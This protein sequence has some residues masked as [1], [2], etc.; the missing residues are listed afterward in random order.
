MV[1][2]VQVQRNSGEYAATARRAELMMAVRRRVES[3][4]IG[5]KNVRNHLFAVRIDKVTSDEIRQD[6]VL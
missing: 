3:N 1:T 5:C 4:D 2:S 6:F